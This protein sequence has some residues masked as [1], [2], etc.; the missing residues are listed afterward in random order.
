M[1]YRK[2]QVNKI[3]CLL[4]SYFDIGQKTQNH[5]GFCFFIDIFSMPYRNDSNDNCRV[6]NFIDN[7]V[8][9]NTN[10]VRIFINDLLVGVWPWNIVSEV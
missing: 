7:P 3:N 2:E 6:V 8:I 5:A 4:S 9:T 10:T 1:L